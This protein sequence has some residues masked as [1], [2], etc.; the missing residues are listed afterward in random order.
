VTNKLGEEMAQKSYS[1]NQ[2]SISTAKLAEINA[3][4]GSGKTST[5]IKRLLYLAGIGVPSE[6]ILVLSFSKS[7]VR[8][9]RRIV[10]PDVV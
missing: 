3:V 2:I 5:L 7:A 1:S 10:S 8:E 4:A 9:L 6:Q